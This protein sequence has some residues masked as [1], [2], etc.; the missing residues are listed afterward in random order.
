MPP[1]QGRDTSRDTCNR[2]FGVCGAWPTRHGQHPL[3]S[4]RRAACQVGPLV[5]G[6]VVFGDAWRPPEQSTVQPCESRC[7]CPGASGVHAWRPMSARPLQV[8]LRRAQ[9]C[10]LKGALETGLGVSVGRSGPAALPPKI[11]GHAQK[12]IDFVRKNYRSRLRARLRA[13]L[14]ARLRGHLGAHLGAPFDVDPPPLPGL[15]PR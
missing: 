12:N 14:R 6:V 1:G 10:S 9:E 8:T 15:S 3:A 4:V 7:R 2:W 13:H 5:Q 11:S